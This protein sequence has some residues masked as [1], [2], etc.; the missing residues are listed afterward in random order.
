MSEIGLPRHVDPSESFLR[1]SPD[2]TSLVLIVGCAIACPRV[3]VKLPDVPYTYYI[4]STKR[5][6]ISV[7]SLRSPAPA[8][9]TAALADTRVTQ[10]QVE[11]VAQVQEAKL[12]WQ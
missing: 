9:M 4:K 3:K 5:G 6:L 7:V 11:V 10:G 8:E 12:P 2:M 1:R